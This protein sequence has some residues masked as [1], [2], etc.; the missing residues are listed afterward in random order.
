MNEETWTLLEKYNVAYCN[1]DEPLLPPEVHVTT[2]FAYFRWHGH[3]INPW[4]DYRYKKEELRPWIPKLKVTAGKVKKNLWFFQQPLP[5][6]RS[7]KLSSSLRNVR[8]SHSR[9]NTGKKQSGRTLQPKVEN[10]KFGPV[11]LI[12]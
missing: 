2:D 3:G 8:S 7:R 9:T 11:F 1:V 4:F 5:W 12:N 10:V 6:I